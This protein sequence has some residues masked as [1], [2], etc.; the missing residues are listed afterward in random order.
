[1]SEKGGTKTFG[2]TERRPELPA[3][4]KEENERCAR[5]W[6]G[7]GGEGRG[8]KK[9]E[10]EGEPRRSKDRTRLL[11]RRR[12]CERSQDINAKMERYSTY[13]HELDERSTET[14]YGKMSAHSIASCPNVQPCRL[15][16]HFHYTLSYI[17]IQPP[18][19]MELNNA[20]G[21]IR[22]QYVE[23]LFIGFSSTSLVVRPLSVCVCP[24]RFS[25]NERTNERSLSS[26]AAS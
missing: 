13:S 6:E 19:A 5:V 23:C 21:R 25:G 12:K 3:R 1:M 26:P 16:V 15:H 14:L 2:R 20:Y 22:M 24:R 11:A 7:K 8:G 18:N 9:A 10:R 4:R 17:C